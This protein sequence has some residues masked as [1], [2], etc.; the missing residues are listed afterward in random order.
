M[1]IKV[2]TASIVGSSQI[3]KKQQ[4]VLGFLEANS[5]AFEQLDVAMND[6]NRQWMRTNVPG[7]RCPQSGIPLPPQIFNEDQYCGDYDGFF[8]A[9]ENEAIPSFLCLETAEK[10]EEEMGHNGE[11]TAE[12]S[13]SLQKNE[14]EEAEDATAEE[15]AEDAT[16]EE[17]AEEVTAEE[18]NTD[19]KEKEQEQE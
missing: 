10:A 12:T 13:E 7:E 17:E 1:V 18:D 3:K 8:D 19:G 5:I 14:E 11:V 2:F 9:K 16:A 4:D 6:G 15:E